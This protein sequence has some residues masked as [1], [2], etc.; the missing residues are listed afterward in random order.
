MLRELAEVLWGD[1]DGKTVREHR[2]GKGRVVWGRSSGETLRQRGIGPD[3][4]FTAGPLGADLDFIHRRTAEADALAARILTATAEA[5]A[6]LAASATTPSVYAEVWHDPMT[7][8]GSDTF[9]AGLVRLAGGRTIAASIKKA[10]FQISPEQVI[11]ENPDVILCLYM[12]PSD[13]AA[14]AV[15]QR[16]GW[17]HV[18]AVQTDR[19]FEGLNNDILLR[20]GPRL[21]AGLD[22]LRACMKQAGQQKQP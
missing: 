9:L 5:R 17:E 14:D 1:C 21:L 8:I 20:P 15:K 18:T 3:F 7:T 11:A 13:G 16:P 10:Y 4:R 6:S 19:V 22:A 12:G 2:H